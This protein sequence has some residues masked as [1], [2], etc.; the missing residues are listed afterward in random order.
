MQGLDEAWD[1]LADVAKLRD[2]VNTQ[3]RDSNEMSKI[4]SRR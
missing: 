3:C 1:R 2:V 4:R